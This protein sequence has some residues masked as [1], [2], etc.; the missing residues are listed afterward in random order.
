MRLDHEI[1]QHQHSETSKCRCQKGFTVVCFEATA[2]VSENWLA[3]IHKLPDL[4]PLHQRF[5]AR[6]IVWRLRHATQRL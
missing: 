4:C 3:A 2:R 6:E 5:M 1:R